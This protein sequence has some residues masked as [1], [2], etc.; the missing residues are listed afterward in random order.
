MN[1]AECHSRIKSPANAGTGM[2]SM[3]LTESYVA[4][5]A[6]PAVRDI[7][8]GQLLEQAAKSAPDRIALIS[9]VADPAFRRQ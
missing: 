9:G 8:L 5:P 2:G 6:V 7:T 1:S 3:A 4:G